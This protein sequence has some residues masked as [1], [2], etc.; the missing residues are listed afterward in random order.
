R[1][2]GTR[3]TLLRAHIEDDPI[4]P[5]REARLAAKIR[6]AAMHPQKDFLSEILGARA[7]DA[8]SSNQSEHQVLVAVDQFRKRALVALATALD[9]L[10]LVDGLHSTRD[11]R[12]AAEENCFN[13]RRETIRGPFQSNQVR[14]VLRSSTCVTV[15]SG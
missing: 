3:R 15:C 4:N 8:R 11:I 12:A 1:V 7:I 13:K 14:R 5:R 10:A 2:V 6:Q 9:E